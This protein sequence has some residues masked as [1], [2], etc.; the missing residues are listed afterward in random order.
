MAD[1]EPPEDSQRDLEVDSDF[2]DADTLDAKDEAS[3][4]SEGSADAQDSDR[5]PSPTKRQKR[6]RRLCYAVIAVGLLTLLV[7]LLWASTFFGEKEEEEVLEIAPTVLFETLCKD[8]VKTDSNKLHVTDFEVTDDMMKSIESMEQLDTVILDKGK[9]S[10]K[11]LHTLI[12]LPNLQ[13]LRLRLSPIT[14]EGLQM[15][16]QCE[17]LWYINLPH[18]ECS[19]KGIESLASLPK[20]RQ[21]RIGGEGLGNE[22][23]L[24]VARIESLRGVHLIGVKVTDDGLRVL[25]DMPNLESLYLDDSAVTEAGWSWLFKTHPELHVHVNQ[26]HHDRDPHSHNHR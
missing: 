25:A 4:D 22:V 2:E 3:V 21:L 12:G 18:A 1:E 5:N 7:G 8:V 17:T 13:H 26:S 23:A 6:V 14:D 9:V 19:A 16:A 10:D 11:A 20:L 15:L 24:A